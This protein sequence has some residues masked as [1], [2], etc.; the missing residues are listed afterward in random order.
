MAT[1][2]V[3][4]PPTTIH[5]SSPW[6][7][8]KRSDYGVLDENESASGRYDPDSD[9]ASPPVAFS[10]DSTIV[11]SIPMT[12]QLGW[13]CAWLGDRATSVML[14]I[15]RATNMDNPARSVVDERRARTTAR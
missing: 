8:A 7:T 11:P 3:T 15:T 1:V 12:H 10:L 5:S 4:Y 14:T 13:A 6:L 2:R 9:P